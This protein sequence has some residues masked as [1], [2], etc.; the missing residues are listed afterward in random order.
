MENPEVTSNQDIVSEKDP[1]DEILKTFIPPT[2]DDILFE[3]FQAQISFKRST[4]VE[5]YSETKI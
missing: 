3:E 5:G 2:E 1:R 4:E